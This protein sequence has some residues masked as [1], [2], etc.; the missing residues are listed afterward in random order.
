MASRTPE[1][2]R[3]LAGRSARFCLTRKV[4]SALVPPLLDAWAQAL[5]AKSKDANRATAARPHWEDA[6]DL[7]AAAP[8]FKKNPSSWSHRVAVAVVAAL[9]ALLAAYLSLYQLHL[10]ASVWDPV[11]GAGTERVLTSPLSQTLY[12]IFHVPDALL[13]AL[14]YSAEILFT[15]AGSTRRWQ[16]RPWLVALFGL[17]VLGLA[18]G[19]VALMAAQGLVVKSWC[20]WCLITTSISLLLA[21]LS[22]K[23]VYASFHYLWRVHEHSGRFQV[24]RDAF[25]GRASE[26]ADRAALPKE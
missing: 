20:F 9:G 21:A 16:Y 17:N 24:V 2:D 14:A 7:D 26:P 8:P 22:A 15:L 4:T 3:P 23:E 11:F 5:L 12:R 18:C 1:K 19:G 6:V 10:T 25:W 13:G